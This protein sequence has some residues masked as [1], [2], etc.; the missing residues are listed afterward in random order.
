MLYSAKVDYNIWDVPLMRIRMDREYSELQS[1][2]IIRWVLALLAVVS[3]FIVLMLYLPNLVKLIA[4]II[5]V[6]FLFWYI[7]Y[8]NR[9]INELNNNQ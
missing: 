4:G 7:K 3:V 2:F 9:K 8:G 6:P 1:A 5:Y